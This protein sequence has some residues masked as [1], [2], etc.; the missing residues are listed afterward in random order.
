MMYLKSLRSFAEA[1]WGF[2]L[3]FGWSAALPM[4]ADPPVSTFEAAYVLGW[5]GSW[6]LMGGV[7]VFNAWR[8]RRR[9]RAVP[10]PVETPHSPGIPAR[11]DPALILLGFK[12]SPPPRKPVSPPPPRCD[13]RCRCDDDEPDFIDGMFDL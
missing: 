9:E 1:V 8:N 11:Q 5:C 12:H 7:W 10:E 13:C 6:V 4:A 2:W 3:V